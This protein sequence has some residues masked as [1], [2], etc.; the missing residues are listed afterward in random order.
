MGER[1]AFELNVHKNVLALSL[2]TRKDKVLVGDLMKSLSVL[3]VTSKDPLKVELTATDTKPA[4]TTAV[5]FIND[6]VFMGADD[7]NNIFVLALDERS[8]LNTT[9][10][11]LALKGGFHIGSLINCFRDGNYYLPLFR[12]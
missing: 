11:K 7:R 12:S 1:V 3:S 9:V 6:N 4:W 10:P 2:D 8:N 5:K